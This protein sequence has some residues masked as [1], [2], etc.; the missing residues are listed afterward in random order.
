MVTYPKL[1]GN[2]QKQN[3]AHRD[4]KETWGWHI[5]ELLYF[6][7]KEICIMQIIPVVHF[8]YAWWRRCQMGAVKSHIE[9]KNWQDLILLD[10]Q[11]NILEY[12]EKFIL[13]TLHSISKTSWVHFEGVISCQTCGEKTM[14]TKHNYCR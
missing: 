9:E 7:T 11:Q 12:T 8:M 1:N 10:G 4:R 13:V 6:I 2:T 5:S 14:H 3:G